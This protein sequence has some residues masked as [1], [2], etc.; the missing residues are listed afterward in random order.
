MPAQDG[1]AARA[2]IVG[3]T[4]GAVAEVEQR[5]ERAGDDIGCTGAGV[6]IGYLHGCRREIGIARIPAFGREL[7]QRRSKR[8]NRVQRLFGIRHMTLHAAHAERRRQRTAPTHANAITQ[9][10]HAGGFADNTPINTFAGGAE[11]LD[12]LAHAI[13]VGRSFLVGR[14]QQADPPAMLRPCRDELLQR[15][16]HRRHRTFHV[17]RTTAV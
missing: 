13:Q 11:V 7:G 10:L 4:G 3:A 15:D 16:H 14:Q 17:R 2:Q 8:V 9:R 1:L 5:G 12:H 6:E